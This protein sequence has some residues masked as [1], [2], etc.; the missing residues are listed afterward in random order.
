MKCPK[1]ETEM[2]AGSLFCPR[3]GTSRSAAASAG[4]DLGSLPTLRE[5]RPGQKVFQRFTL[6]RILGRGGMGVVWLARDEQ[7]DRDVALKFL[8]DVVAFNRG[9]V[10]DL[11]R[12]TRR[13][14]D[15]THPHIVRIHDLLQEISAAGISMEYVAGDTLANLRAD[16]PHG[17]FSVAQLG[18]WVR[19]LCAALQYAHEQGKVVHRDLKPANLMVD[20]QGRVK[21]ADFG[22]S[23]SLTDSVSRMTQAAGSSGTLAYASPQQLDGE[24]PSVADD[25]YSLGATLYEVL[26]SKPPFHSGNIDRQVRE[27]VPPSLTERR[28]ELGVPG[29]AIP[30]VWETAIA[31]CLAK[32]PAQRPASANE[33]AAR[34][35]LAKLTPG[36]AQKPATS[37]GA[38]KRRLLAVAAVAVAVVGFL[39]WHFA[40]T[41]PNR[42][43]AATQTSASV[44]P[45]GGAAAHPATAEPPAKAPAV[46]ATKVRT[47]PPVEC[48][49]KKNEASQARTKARAY[50]LDGDKT[51]SQQVDDLENAW[52]NAETAYQKEDWK[53]AFAGYGQVLNLEENLKSSVAQRGAA[54]KAKESALTAQSQAQQS[55]AGD[56]AASQWQAAEGQ[57][58]SAETQLAAGKFSESQ[59]LFEDAGRQYNRAKRQAEEAQE[60]RKAKA[61]YEGLLRD[62]ANVALLEKCGGSNWAGIKVQVQQAE[63]AKATEAGRQLY[64]GARKRLPKAVEV[65]SAAESTAQQLKQEEAAQTKQKREKDEADADMKTAINQDMA[66]ARKAVQDQNWSRVKQ[67]AN[68]VL[69]RDSGHTEAGQLRALAQ[70]HRPLETGER[71]T[72]RLGMVFAPIS[73]TNILFCI[74]ETR[75]QDYTAFANASMRKWRNPDYASGS[76]Y[77]AVDLSWDDANAFCAWLTDYERKQDATFTNR[78]YRLPTDVEWSR[79][80][81]LPSEVGDTPDQRDRQNRT[82]YPW[83]QGWPPP[84]N[85]DNYAGKKWDSFERL[86]PVGSM[87]MNKYGLY[88]MGGNVSE[89]CEDWLKP[90]F[91]LLE[92]KARV[93]RGASWKKDGKDDILL[94]RREWRGPN[95]R[96]DDL[97]FR[98]VLVPSGP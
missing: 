60:Y 32:Q 72:N 7:L 43:Q 90:K 64:E 28:K 22:I 95:G 3:C 84:S 78:C 37:K 81:G 42:R 48:A 88:D 87:T 44:P 65:A 26:T 77:P 45:V 27:K 2:G 5:Y 52:D 15:L 10:E 47:D 13:A 96:S 51:L 11:K 56:D 46:E 9:A 33:L 62:T 8:P 82:A 68:S 73:E 53:M 23:R 6:K 17:V 86:A 19:D 54:V 80:A 85:A 41:V 36:S 94:S 76:T 14:L 34:L 30:P 55:R 31:A 83:G 67:L 24:P 18:P 59:T 97:G 79:A 70:F 57:R 89:W 1:C 61:D 92:A 63:E 49:Q 4:E 21:I 91:G 16:Q 66:A 12:E 98:V 93:L 69:G 71:W 74:W 29:E 38:K 58:T 39:V 20:D 40:V 75:V 35:G 50:K 25:I